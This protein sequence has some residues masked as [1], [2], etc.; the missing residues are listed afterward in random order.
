M[1]CTRAAASVR[2]STAGA[3]KR[4][5]GGAGLQVLRLVIDAIQ[6]CNLRCKYCH[7][8][9]VWVRRH[10]DA[11]YVRGILVAAERHGCLEVV[12]SATTAARCASGLTRRR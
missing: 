6:E 10:L 7:P 3:A 8:G 4:G 5:P 2:A 11:E 1:E 12:L 9:E